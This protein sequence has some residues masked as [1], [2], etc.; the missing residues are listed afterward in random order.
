LLRELAECADVHNRSHGC[1]LDDGSVESN[2]VA[3][4]G[5]PT[6]KAI[7]AYR[8]GLDHFAG[9]E[10]NYYGHYSGVGEID[11]LDR[12]ARF[13]K[14]RFLWKLDHPQMWHERSHIFGREGSQE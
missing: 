3:N 10:I 1:N 12:I 5:G 13:E 7:P 4:S 9:G 11:A 2:I 8:C 6:H 14:Y